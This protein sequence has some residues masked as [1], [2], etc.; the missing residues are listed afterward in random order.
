MGFHPAAAGCLTSSVPNE[1]E[2][3]RCS[4]QSAAEIRPWYTFQ[5]TVAGFTVVL[6]DSV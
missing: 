3:A 4:S 1:T 2:M 6:T 5:M